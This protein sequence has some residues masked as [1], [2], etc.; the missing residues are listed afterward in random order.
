[1]LCNQP[2]QTKKKKNLLIKLLIH[3]EKQVKAYR[4]RT[5]R[6]LMGWRQVAA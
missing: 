5:L 2:V 1:M 6:S 4:G 3:E